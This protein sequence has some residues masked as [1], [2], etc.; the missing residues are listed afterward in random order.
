MN[1]TIK[2]YISQQKKQKNFDFS[3][4]IK[5][6]LIYNKI[7]K[8]KEINDMSNKKK[9]KKKTLS[10][11]DIIELVIKAMLAAAALIQSIKS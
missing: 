9:A 2:S 6:N 10:A 5:L 3:I 1:N 8:G 7:I 4:D 11:K